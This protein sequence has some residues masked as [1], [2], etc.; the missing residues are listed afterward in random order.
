VNKTITNF[1]CVLCA[2]GILWTPYSL[3]ASQQLGTNQVINHT[4]HTFADYPNSIKP[5]VETLQKLPEVRALLGKINEEGPIRISLH[6]DKQGQFDAFWDGEGRTILLN[7]YRLHKK[8]D[9]LFSILFEMHNA[10]TDQTINKLMEQASLNQISKDEWVRS[11]EYMEFQNSLNTCKLVEK[12]I[13]SGVFPRDTPINIF[14]TFDVYYWVQQIMGHSDWHANT[15]DSV[16]PKGV[17]TPYRKTIP[18]FSKMT[19]QDKQDLLRYLFI[20]NSL[21]SYHAKESLQGKRQLRQEFA[22]LEG[23]FKGTSKGD[24]RNYQKAKLLRLV[25]QGTHEFDSL[26]ANAGISSGQETVE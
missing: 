19:E 26:L 3:S 24:L 17:G 23:C 15:Y 20:K 5:I 8:G 6:Q 11:M 13:Q 2:I 9:W 1:S 18:E 21:E 7:P 14:Y 4:N 25:F 16:N 22:H 12:G 10:S